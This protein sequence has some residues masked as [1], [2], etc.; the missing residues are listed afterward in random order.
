[1]SDGQTMADILAQKAVERDDARSKAQQNAAKQ[2]E[3]LRTKLAKK[4]ANATI[5]KKGA[6][7]WT[8]A[9]FRSRLNAEDKIAKLNRSVLD[10]AEFCKRQSDDMKQLFQL[11]LDHAPQD[12]WNDLRNRLD[13]N[14]VFQGRATL[15]AKE[16]E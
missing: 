12:A 11:C 9:F 1:M 3:I 2:D 15:I 6:F 7:W 10:Y 8:P 16:E 5:V 13:P 4:I 14:G